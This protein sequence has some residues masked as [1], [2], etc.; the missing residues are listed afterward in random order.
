MVAESWFG[1]LFKKSTGLD[2]KKPVK[3]TIGVLSLEVASVMSK[4]VNLW[5]GLTDEQIVKLREEIMFSVGIKKLVSDDED[6]LDRLVCAEVIE[7]LMLVVKSVGRFG[8]KCVSPVLQ[9]FENVF[10]DLVKND[11]DL[12]GWEYSYKKMD[13]KSKKLDKYVRVT[14]N[15]YQ[16]MEA[17]SDLE[18]A[19]RKLRGIGEMT[20][21]NRN[22]FHKKVIWQRQEV[23]SLRD[24]S[25]WNKTFDDVVLVLAR[26]LFTIMRRI[27]HLF[28]IDQ[29]L[30][31][32]RE[33]E[34]E[35]TYFTPMTTDRLPRSRSIS[36]LRQMSV[37]PAEDNMTRFAS[38]PLRRST[39]NSGPL[40]R[41][42]TSSGPLGRSSVKSGPLGR[43]STKSGPLGRSNTK[44]G[45]IF[46]SQKTN[47]REWETPGKSS[48]TKTKRFTPVRPFKGC[49]MPGNIS[50]VIQS[51]TPL[52]GYTSSD[53]IYSGTL[54]GTKDGYVELLA[55]RSILHGNRL[56]YN[57]KARLLTAPPETLGAA[58]L[59]SHY[60]DVII[61][62]EKYVESPQLIGSDARDDLY[63]M[64]TTSIKATLRERLKSYVKSSA[65]SYHD[66]DLA[67]EWREALARIVEWLAPLAHNMKR[68]QSERSFQQQ[69]LVSRTN[70][71]LV[72][73]LFFAN[74]AKTEAA[75][76][77]L[78][79][80]LNYL[81][82]FYSEL[83][84]KALLECTSSIEFDDYLD[85][86]GSN[87]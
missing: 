58:A 66:T 61:V 9:R 3:L 27:N 24:S 70:V 73:T 11:E 13:K 18:L 84:E 43:L 82:R 30:E 39:A 63:D 69:H 72:Q 59:A 49:I 52:N 12:F 32:E 20:S 62:I 81:W 80:G 42:A 67:E 64:L 29:G 57:S 56:R 76:T 37:H 41:Y 47:Y 35:V 78:L 4:A 26:S 54:D 48:R 75:I 79:V 86:K 23:K 87:L 15:L 34:R 45:P 83:N 85:S 60:A 33:R 40:G 77:E 65:S 7:S 17:L 16:E 19:V 68:W 38:G 25:L 28:G 36:A 53:G 14:S 50:P 1:G 71:L 44:S 51:C 10:D 22:E 2:R 46:G 31:Q 6:Y 74:Q 5:R 55:N 8:K 21:S